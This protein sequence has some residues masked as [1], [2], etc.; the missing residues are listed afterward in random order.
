MGGAAAGGGPNPALQVF[1]NMHV[2]VDTINESTPDIE[3]TCPICLESLFE[4]DDTPIRLP[5]CR[6][7][8]FH[9]GCIVCVVKNDSL[10][11]PICMAVYGKQQTGNQPADGTMSIRNEGYRLPGFPSSDGAIVITYNFPD[12]VQV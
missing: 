6:G 7:H 3:S 8:A 12:G 11:C 10:K 4:T 2:E 5:Q 1:V 9:A